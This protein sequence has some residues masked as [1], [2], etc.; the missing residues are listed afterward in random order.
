[1]KKSKTSRSSHSNNSSFMQDLNMS[2]RALVLNEGQSYKV[3]DEAFQR[4]ER[5]IKSN[6]KQRS[7]TEKSGFM[8]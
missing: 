4:P 2:K 6:L 3:Q 1:M 5:K 8:S 7:V